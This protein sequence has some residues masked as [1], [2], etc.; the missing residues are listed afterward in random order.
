MRWIVWTRYSMDLTRCS[1]ALS[2]FVSFAS[3]RS[4]LAIFDSILV[5]FESNI[6]SNLETRSSSELGALGG[7]PGLGL[8]IG[9][10]P[11]LGE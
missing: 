10:F 9:I 2:I 8:G 1:R 11:I 4:M 7:G 3:S 5:N 6:C